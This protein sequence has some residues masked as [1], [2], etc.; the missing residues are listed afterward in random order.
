MNGE[1]TCIH[2]ACERCH[3]QKLRCRRES[4]EKCIR[5]AKANAECVART[6]LRTRRAETTRCRSRTNKPRFSRSRTYSTAQRSSPD[7]SIHN[8]VGD[9]ENRS[10]LLFRNRTPIAAT[11][12]VLIDDDGLCPTPKSPLGWYSTGGFDLDFL[13]LGIDPDFHTELVSDEA[14]SVALDKA[15]CNAF[16]IEPADCH[17]ATERAIPTPLSSE[18][19]SMLVVGTSSTDGRFTSSSGGNALLKTAEPG[20]NGDN[21]QAFSN[22]LRLIFGK[23]GAR[24]VS[25]QTFPGFQFSETPFEVR[26]TGASIEPTASAFSLADWVE[27]LAKLNSRVSQHGK[28]MAI[29]MQ[30]LSPSTSS[31]SAPAFNETA[32]RR[33][34][35][36]LV[37]D[38]SRSLDETLALSTDLIQ[39]LDQLSSQTGESPQVQRCNNFQS[40]FQ[41]R[42]ANLP[43]RHRGHLTP[44]DEENKP[45]SPI[46]GD[47]FTMLLLISCYMRLIGIYEDFF[48]HIQLNLCD[49]KSLNE[50]TQIHLPAIT[51]GSFS[52]RSSPVLEALLVIELVTFLV[53]HL[54]H[55]IEL[56]ASTANSRDDATSERSSKSSSAMTDVTS[57]TLKAVREREEEL[58]ESMSRIRRALM[59]SRPG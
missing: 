58:I 35:G 30:C 43:R 44:A 29:G 19:S 7:P 42:M 38:E 15:G 47:Q 3:S 27:D 21:S 48:T 24:N 46:H 34:R 53:R 33:E 26:S 16:G 45:Q 36:P 31:E 55:T 18:N 28:V 10:M 49:F 56:T 5:C 39:L 1:D 4:K 13:N 12:C 41:G 32:G 25:R 40:S 54:G 52:L 11:D 57:S 20:Y 2:R 14:L 59:R 8:E 17:F 51:V 37:H 23:E 9:N 22:P 6:P 50:S